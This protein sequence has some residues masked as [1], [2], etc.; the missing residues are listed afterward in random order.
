MDA[1]RYRHITKEATALGEGRGKWLS[2]PRMSP[3]SAL[4]TPLAPRIGSDGRMKNGQTEYDIRCEWGENAVRLLASSSDAVVIVDV[5]SFCTCVSI[6]VSRGATV[7]PWPGDAETAADF[8]LSIG[9]ELAGPR[10]SAKYSLSPRSMRNVPSGLRLVLPSP[11]G[12]A[13][14]LAA[15]TT[16]TLAGCLRN[17]TSVAQAAMSCGQRITVIPAGE[18]WSADHSLRPAIEDLLGAGA[19]IQCLHGTRSPEATVALAAYEAHVADLRSLLWDCVSGREL[20]AMGFEDDLPLIADLDADETA[21]AL[22][23]GAFVRPV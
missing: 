7:F 14:S 9:A 8:A 2:S 13:L 16:T 15:G 12:S 11:N 18:R 21:P 19:I 20:I 17:R 3:E 5:M 1:G 10:D 4:D 6:A 22:E 23:D